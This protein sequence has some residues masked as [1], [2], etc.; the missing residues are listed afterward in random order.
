VTYKSPKVFPTDAELLE[1]CRN[2]EPKAQSLLYEKYG[3]RMKG[4]CRRYARSEEDV[5]DIFQDAFVRV[6][7][8]LHT[9]QNPETMIFWMKKIFINTAINHYHKHLKQ[10]LN[11]SDDILAY[12]STND[13]D[14]IM[15]D[16][17]TNDLLKIVKE[18]PDGFRVVFNMYAIDGFQHSEIA[19]HLGITESTSKSQYSRAKEWLRKRLKEIGIVSYETS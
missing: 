14:L 19:A 10:Q 5:E 16:L 17:S 6:F 2:N 13:N 18:L 4:L 11:V 12:H 1:R 3:S 8:N 9:V 15:S 7:Q